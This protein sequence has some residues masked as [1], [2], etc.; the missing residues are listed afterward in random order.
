MEVT[1]GCCSCRAP[2]ATP[3]SPSSLQCLAC[4]GCSAASKNSATTSLEMLQIAQDQSK[5]QST[6]HAAGCCS[7]GE[8]F[9]TA[10]SISSSARSNAYPKSP[11]EKSGKTLNTRTAIKCSELISLF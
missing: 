6:D 5:K 11:N 8:A 1:T 2:S 9:C 7:K 4:P 3:P 10:C